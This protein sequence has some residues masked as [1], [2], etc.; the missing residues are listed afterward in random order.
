[1]V[2]LVVA[3]GGLLALED[4]VLDGVRAGLEVVLCTTV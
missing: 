2:A 1:M 4:G 3:A